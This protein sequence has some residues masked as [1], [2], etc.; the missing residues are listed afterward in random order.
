[1]VIQTSDPFSIMSSTTTIT[2][3]LISLISN[4]ISS[5]SYKVDDIATYFV[6]VQTNYPFNSISI[7]LPSD[8]SVE[9]GYKATCLPN[10][11][12]SCDI[13]GNNMTF[14]GTLSSGSYTLSWGNNINP[15]SFA[16]T[17]TFSIFTYFRGWGV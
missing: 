16:V 11:F 17:G 3:S 7:I 12:T 5:S 8:V 6:N 13:V 15:N 4:S 10:T 14:T 2:V 9:S 1:M